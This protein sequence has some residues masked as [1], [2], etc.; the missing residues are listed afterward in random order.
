MK[1]RQLTGTDRTKRCIIVNDQH[2][3]D[4]LPWLFSEMPSA[5]ARLSNYEFER[6]IIDL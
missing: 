2:E 4:D 5:K 3:K 1:S 6:L